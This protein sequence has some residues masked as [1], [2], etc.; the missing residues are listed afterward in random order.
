M[1]VIDSRSIGCCEHGCLLLLLFLGVRTL[2]VS[3]PVR[4][5]RQALNKLRRRTAESARVV[6]VGP[7]GLAQSQRVRSAGNASV[8]TRDNGC[9]E[10]QDLVR[11]AQRIE[12]RS[13]ASISSLL[14]GEQFLRYGSL[15]VTSAAKLSV[16]G[17]PAAPL[18]VPAP[19][20]QKGE[21][22]PGPT[23]RLL[24]EFLRRL[25]TPRGEMSLE[26]LRGLFW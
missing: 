19:S 22:E 11:W 21:R 10:S 1:G 23:G 26:R 8:R 17:N 25:L 14:S 18:H 15:Q 5:I 7:F 9:F 20:L 16:E 3:L 13:D 4:Q 2:L 6:L 24:S 12:S